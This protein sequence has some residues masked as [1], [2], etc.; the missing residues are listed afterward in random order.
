[1]TLRS[2]LALCQWKFRL[3]TTRRFLH[4]PI[5]S[6]LPIRRLRRRMG[7][8]KWRVWVVVVVVKPIF[9][10]HKASEAIESTDRVGGEAIFMLRNRAAVL[11]S[12]RAWRS[13]PDRS[14]FRETLFLE[15]PIPG[16]ARLAHPRTIGR[17]HVFRITGAFSRAG[18]HSVWAP[19]SLRTDRRLI[20]SKQRETIVLTANSRWNC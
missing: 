5:F 17:N 8:K 9:R 12:T 3:E 10:W 4:P 16:K 11:R 13:E 20:R 18:E 1:V 19:A 7:R 15:T 2:P 14:W 6:F